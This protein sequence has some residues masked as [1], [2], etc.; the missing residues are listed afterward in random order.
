M[1]SLPGITNR[2]SRKQH[3]GK[4]PCHGEEHEGKDVNL[5][6]AAAQCVQ[7]SDPRLMHEVLAVANKHPELIDKPRG[8]PLPIYDCF[9]R[10]STPLFRGP[11]TAIMSSG[12]PQ[13]YR[14]ALDVR[15][16]VL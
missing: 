4:A 11:C 6:H 10:V 15:N 13:Q 14:E 3:A 16:E 2:R 5:W 7:I 9:D 8:F 1:L 12:V